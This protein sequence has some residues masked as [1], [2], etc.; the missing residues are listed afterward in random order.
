[1]VNSGN[2]NACTGKRHAGRREGP[3][4][5]REIAVPVEQVLVGST[6]RI[7]VLMPMPQ[8]K[9]GSRHAGNCSVTRAA[10]RKPRRSDQ[11]PADC[12]R[13]KLAG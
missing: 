10:P 6:G 11:H 13:F 9:S 12:G 7:G 4:C 8:V 5:W 1:M 3:R 2:A